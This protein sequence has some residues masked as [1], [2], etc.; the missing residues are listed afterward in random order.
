MRNDHNRQRV[1]T[2]EILADICTMFIKVLANIRKA[3]NCQYSFAMNNNMVEK[4]EF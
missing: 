1:R 2:E 4:V 3:L